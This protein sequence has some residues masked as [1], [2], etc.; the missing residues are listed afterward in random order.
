M[1]E[2]LPGNYIAGFVD[3]EGCFALK[4]RRDI[5]HDRKG[6]PTYY[7]WGIEFAI[8]LRTD[9]TA[10]LESIQ[11]TL[12]CG[13]I[14]VGNFNTAR[15]SVNRLEDLSSIV[16]PFFEKYPLHAKKKHDFFLW[17]E[18]LRILNRNR[19]SNMMRTDR[20]I[21]FS[22]IKWKQTD[23][24]RL[25]EIREDMKKYKS[26]QDNDWKWLGTLKKSRLTE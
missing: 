18:A 25:L 19:Q 16:V 13:R 7:Y 21:G 22:K 23:I 9:D 26:F 24:D 10:I 20:Q 11:Y 15:F 8:V 14:S 17:E 2:K 6:S 1:P 5:R 12:G 3:G 4:F